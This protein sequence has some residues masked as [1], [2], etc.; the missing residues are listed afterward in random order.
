MKFK[1]NWKDMPPEEF[2]K[3]VDDLLWVMERV[4]VAQ[5]HAERFVKAAQAAGWNPWDTVQ[6]IIRTDGLL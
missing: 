6:F 4:T 1:T 5:L 3:E 2:M